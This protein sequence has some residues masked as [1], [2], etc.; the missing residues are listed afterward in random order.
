MSFYS[1]MERE[2]AIRTNPQR[3]SLDQTMNS[4]ILVSVQILR[5][6]HRPSQCRYLQWGVYYLSSGSLIFSCIFFICSSLFSGDIVRYF[7]LAHRVILRYSSLSSG[8]IS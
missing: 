2:L 1:G 6:S 4:P 5:P 8:D 7:S 3:R